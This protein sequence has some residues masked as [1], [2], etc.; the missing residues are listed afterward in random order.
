MA[1]VTNQFSLLKW[2]TTGTCYNWNKEHW[3]WLKNTL[4][5]TKLLKSLYSTE[6]HNKNHNTLHVTYVEENRNLWERPAFTDVLCIGE[7]AAQGDEM[8]A[9]AKWMSLTHLPVLLF[10][11]SSQLCCKTNLHLSPKEGETVYMLFFV[12]YEQTKLKGPCNIN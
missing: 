11:C 10:L 4:K 8:R 6:V 9:W 7:A 2:T 12:L 5:H 3:C 1:P